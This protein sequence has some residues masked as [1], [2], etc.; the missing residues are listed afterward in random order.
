MNSLNIKKT[1]SCRYI[2]HYI[3]DFSDEK[4]AL[5]NNLFVPLFEG[6]DNYVEN[7]TITS[8]LNLI[9][10]S[11]SFFKHSINTN[12][13]DKECLKM[14]KRFLEY[15][16]KYSEQKKVYIFLIKMIDISFTLKYIKFI[17]YLINGNIIPSD[18]IEDFVKYYISPDLYPTHAT[19]MS[20]IGQYNAYYI[21]K[22]YLNGNDTYYDNFNLTYLNYAVLNREFELLKV[23]ME[24]N[25]PYNNPYSNMN[26]YFYLRMKSDPTNNF[27][28]RIACQYIYTLVPDERERHILNHIHNFF[29]FV[30]NNNIK[31]VIF[32]LNNYSEYT[33]Q[34]INGLTISNVP[35]IGRSKSIE[36]TRILL[37]KGAIIKTKDEKER[38]VYNRIINLW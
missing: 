16:L 4:N 5:N 27:T 29:G 13:I 14:L 20:T 33:T 17:D 35:M 9:C 10:D 24:K 34:I 3:T 18:K 38:I 2:I 36:I 22:K 32:T 19:I 23:L 37:D 30:E 8:I 6:G 7:N 26:N 31:D 28:E 11:K 25:I 15:H 21:F 12:G 1:Y